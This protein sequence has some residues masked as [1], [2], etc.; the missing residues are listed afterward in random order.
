MDDCRPYTWA[1][2]SCSS[3]LYCIFDH[4]Q[5]CNVCYALQLH[6]LEVR[7]LLGGYGLAE[8]GRKR[9]CCLL[10]RHLVW[11]FIPEFLAAPPS[12]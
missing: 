7:W 4:E 5:M 11:S 10:L 6:Q 12:A 1:Q 2:I 3:V 9:T 8:H